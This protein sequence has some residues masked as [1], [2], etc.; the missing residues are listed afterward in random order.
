MWEIA[1]QKSPFSD[2]D[3]GIKAF[4]KVHNRERP[5]MK[6]IVTPSEDEVARIY[7]DEYLKIMGDAWE[8]EP[9]KRPEI[10]LISMWP[11][12]KM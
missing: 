2:V 4:E 3:S 10:A 7:I 5:D 1:S 9:D 12:K 11:I 8:Q 6:L